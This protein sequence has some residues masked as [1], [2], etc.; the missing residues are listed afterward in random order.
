MGKGFAVIDVE[1]TGFSPEKHDRIVEIGI[2]HV[3]PA[4]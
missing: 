3:S 1:T 4:G 2:V